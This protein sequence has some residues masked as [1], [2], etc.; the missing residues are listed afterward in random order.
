MDLSNFEI[1]RR[2]LELAENRQN[3]RDS[4]TKIV[5]RHLGKISKKN[6]EKSSRLTA[7]IT[8]TDMHALL[9]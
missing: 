5:N 2:Q 9:Q 4:K 6:D 1:Y 7:L 3:I 8:H